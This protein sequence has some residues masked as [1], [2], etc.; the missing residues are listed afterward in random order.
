LQKHLLP[1]PYDP[2]RKSLFAPQW[3]PT[4]FESGKIYTDA[5]I[6]AAATRLAYIKFESS[7]AENAKLA[8]ALSLVGYTQTDTHSNASTQLL[9]TFNPSTH[10]ALIAFR[11]TQTDDISDIATDAY[12]SPTPWAPGGQVH[13]GFADAHQSVYP[14]I[15]AWLAR[16][17]PARLLVTGHSLGAALATLTATLE[18]SAELFTI[19]SPRVGNEAFVKLLETRAVKRFVNCA[20]IV[21]RIPPSG[22]LGYQH[23]PQE[24][25]IDR[26]GDINPAITAS[27]KSQDA[28]AARRHYLAN[29]TWRPG[30]VASRDLADHSPINY[31]YAI[32]GAG[33][34]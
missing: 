6:C 7:P 24:F 15:Q 33:V 11:G 25:Y 30:T 17:R 16:A 10:T 32:L 4:I 12:F 29:E 8:D 22:L 14:W 28:S 2:T 1:T 9:A 20:D 31:V 18:P 5:L 3:Q 13:L 26:H 19:G 21:T 27:E 34:V 23:L